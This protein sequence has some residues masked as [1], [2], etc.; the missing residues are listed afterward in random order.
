M[1]THPESQCESHIEHYTQ[2]HTV[3]VD[4]SRIFHL[5]MPAGDM[6]MTSTE[7]IRLEF[8]LHEM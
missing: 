3:D 8:A 7:T 6:N 2:E 1:W 4:P 5:G